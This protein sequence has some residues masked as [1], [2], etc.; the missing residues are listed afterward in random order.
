MRQQLDHVLREQLP[1]RTGSTIAECGRDVATALTPK[2]FVKKLQR[3]GQKRA[4]LTTCMT[5]WERSEVHERQQEFRGLSGDVVSA[6][7]REIERC[8]R[9]RPTARREEL[10][11]EFRALGTLVARHREEFDDLLKTVDIETL[12]ARRK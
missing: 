9:W 10:A 1:W 4:A 11:T 8:S 3:Q 5:C 6:V 2:E 12:R 7:Y